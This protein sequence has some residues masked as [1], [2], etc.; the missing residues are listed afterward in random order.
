MRM[1]DISFGV[2]R[3]KLLLC[4]VMGKVNS[5]ADGHCKLTSDGFITQV[6]L[7]C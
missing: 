2:P 1:M 4:E 3:C 7:R 5:E 6:A